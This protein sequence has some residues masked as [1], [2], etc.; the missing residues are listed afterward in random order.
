MKVLAED[1]ISLL[2]GDD[3][4]NSITGRRNLA[5]NT[6]KEYTEP[7]TNFNDGGVNQWFFLGNVLTDGLSVG[8]V[9]TVRIVAKVANMSR[10]STDNI[11]TVELLGKGH[12]T[13][14]SSGEFVGANILKIDSD[15]DGPINGELETLR[16]MTINEDHLKNDYWVFIIRAD[17]ITDGSELS[18]KEFKVEKGADPS[19]WTPAPE[20]EEERLT[21][22]ETSITNNANEI[23]LRA[24]QTDLTTVSN[25]VAIIKESTTTFTQNVSGWQFNW[26]KLINATNADPISHQDYITLQ[27]GNII[28]GESGSDLKVK[29][30]ND[31]IQFKGTSDEEITPDDDTTA[32]ITGQKLNINE[33]EVYRKLRIG[34]LVMTPRPNGNL[35]ISIE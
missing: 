3:F 24:K 5:L 27:D 13:G 9:I 30:G 18:W 35:A 16:K 7:I 12:I 34:K 32:W 10:K 20:D 8:D 15:F 28:L 1:T 29:I 11:G 19:P 33:G 23:Q 26:E 14:W 21:S 6:S 25:E 17:N 22:I 31:A 2:Y 4:V